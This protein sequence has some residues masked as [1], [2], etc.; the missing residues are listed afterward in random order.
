MRPHVYILSPLIAIVLLACISCVNQ[1]G[2]SLKNYYLPAAAENEGIVYQFQI[3]GIQSGKEY[4]YYNL[5]QRNDSTRLLVT[6]YD[7][8]L[9]QQQLSVEKPLS[10]GWVQQQLLLFL[11]DSTGFRS[12][13]ATIRTGNRFA[14]DLQD[15]LD[16]LHYSVEWTE[17]LNEVSADKQLIRNS[18]FMGFDTI[19][20][21]GK[22]H[23][24]AHFASR[25]KIEDTRE[26]TLTLDLKSDEY[27]V[28]NWGL[29][30]KKQYFDDGGNETLI[31]HVLLIDTL[32][33]SDLE[34]L[35]KEKQ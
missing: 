19:A 26:G 1:T 23:K 18:R 24:A 8:D 13:K 12:E 31:R 3:K 16:V 14:F 32:Q 34:Q 30:E 25:E 20:C 2:E 27:Y 29:V 35:L 6:V 21:M 33:M 7:E 22:R 17:N 9:N 15:S 10:N 11:R 5:Q 4:W 28:K